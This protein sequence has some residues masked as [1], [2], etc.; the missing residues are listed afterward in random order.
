M[1]GR[2]ERAGTFRFA[3]SAGPGDGSGLV[4]YLDHNAITPVR[5]EAR[6][7]VLAALDA[8][9]NPSSVIWRRIIRQYIAGAGCVMRVS[10]VGGKLAPPYF[11]ALFAWQ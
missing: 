7:A 3:K 5:P 4:I 10:G 11:Q 9:G 8:F 1:A 6:A 2:G